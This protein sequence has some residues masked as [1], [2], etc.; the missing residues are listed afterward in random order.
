MVKGVLRLGTEGGDYDDVNEPDL[1]PYIDAASL[2]VDDVVEC[3]TN[4]GVTLSTAKKEMIERWIAAHAYAMS[5]QTYKRKKTGDAEGEYHGQ[6]GMYLEA[7]KYGQ[8]ALSL[9]P[10]GCLRALSRG[11]AVQA[12]W[13]GKAPSEQVDYEDRD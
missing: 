2:L 10:S 4:K 8:F 9:D 3:A 6:T 12:F 5:D 1:T 13:L 11:V 7:T